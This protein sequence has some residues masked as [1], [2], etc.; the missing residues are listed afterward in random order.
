MLNSEDATLFHVCM[1]EATP[2]VYKALTDLFKVKTL[3]RIMAL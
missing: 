2:E 1:T 3:G